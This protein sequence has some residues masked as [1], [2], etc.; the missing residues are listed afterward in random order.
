AGNARVMRATSPVFVAALAMATGREPFRGRRVAGVAVAFAGTLAL[1]GADRF[2][3]TDAHVVGNLMVLV[4]AMSY[5]A[6]LV[7][8]RPLAL[9]VP[10]MT[11]GGALFAAAIP[12]GLPRGVAEWTA[13]APAMTGRDG[14]LVLL[15]VAATVLAY[16]VN[17]H[18]IGRADASVVALY[19]YLQPILTALGA[20]VL[21]G[22]RP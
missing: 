17:Q 12:F 16:A 4:N 13:F 8:L 2:D 1:V 9:R 20:V 7:Y 21:L 6:F 5:A 19:I 3:L 15:V 10:A 11:P 14:A 18:A 22:E